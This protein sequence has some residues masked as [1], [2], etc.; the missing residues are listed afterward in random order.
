MLAAAEPF[1]MVVRRWYPCST[2]A[3]LP[4]PDTSRI[5][6]DDRVAVDH[7]EAGQHGDREDRAESP[8][9]WRIR[10]NRGRVTVKTAGDCR[11][12]GPAQ[13]DNYARSALKKAVLESRP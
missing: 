12:C 10:P 9:Y 8:P 13:I 7:I 5:R 1:P 6:Q 2:A 3:A 4:S 11:R